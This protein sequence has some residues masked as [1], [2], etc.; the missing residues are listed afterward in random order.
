MHVKYPKVRTRPWR[1]RS[2]F[3]VSVCLI[4]LC[5]GSARSQ[6]T[7][8][9]QREI[10]VPA[11][12][13]LVKINMHLK[14][15]ERF[16]VE[17]SGEWSLDGK[18]FF[19]ADGS[20]ERA[21][22]DFQVSGASQG[23]LIGKINLNGKF[24]ALGSRA[25]KEVEQDGYLYLAINERKNLFAYRDNRGSLKVTVSIIG[26]GA[27]GDA[28]AHRT[29]MPAQPRMAEQAQAPSEVAKPIQ[30]TTPMLS[31]NLPPEVP[32][33]SQFKPFV[34]KTFDKKKGF[35]Q[36][37]PS[38]R[39]FQ[40]RDGTPFFAIGHNDWP[41]A[42]DLRKKSRQQVEAYFRN[43]KAHHV[44][45]L[46]IILDVGNKET[47][48]WVETKPGQ[49]NP[50]FKRWMDT[51]MALAEEYDVYMIFAIYPNLTN[52]AF[53]NMAFY[54]YG[55]RAGGMAE[56]SH[57]MLVNPA[58]K[59][60]EKMRFRFLVDQW[61]S[62]PNILSWELF[63]EFWH[64]DKKKSG[65]ENM[66]IHNAW[67]NEMGKFIKDYEMGK[68]GMHHLR[69][70]STM[71]SEF[72]R[73]RIGVDPSMSQLYTSP[74][75]DYASFHTYGQTMLGAMGSKNDLD[76]VAGKKISTERLVESIHRTMT[77]MLSRAPDRPVIC[78]EDFQIANPKIPE[79]KNPFNVLRKMVAGYSDEERFDLFNVANWAFMMS[80]AAG[81]PE[82]Y[83]SGFYEEE[84]YN[85]YLAL[86]KF[87]RRVPWS[88]F[89]AHP[90]DQQITVKGNDFLAYG[91][92]DSE[93]MIGW[94]YQK[95]P[96]ARRT[97]VSVPVR[98]GG[99]SS[100]TYEILWIDTRTGEEIKKDRIQQM[101]S[102]VASPP[103][104]GHIAFLVQKR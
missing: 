90:A 85:D 70:V 32:G 76:I 18:R 59:E 26:A 47:A 56:D 34:S 16:S 57:D 37:A 60:H 40:F 80:G 25:T 29:E 15:G 13:A 86:S 20:D 63:N 82:R 11:H 83:P 102:Q 81:T 97:Q 51:I 7:I 66:R 3:L 6:E 27:G 87:T 101:P 78:S 9:A 71:R 53:G 88:R 19:G 46:R 41:P 58:A 50:A 55:K 67:I 72:P 28:G 77:M 39:Y 43:C 36:V 12:L 94:L 48:F 98:I 38:R 95:V 93:R 79:Y 8:R 17:A 54:P 91:M 68:F 103:F 96:F 24:F 65:P 73:K 75:L 69:S 4:A 10:D 35:I 2:T 92:A 100:G 44:N 42:F 23:S 31:Q 52:G 99:L 104:K 62:S 89:K 21:G 22:K 84:M 61:G 33:A 49:F 45:V 1:S 64:P 74:E 5:T 14:K 30:D